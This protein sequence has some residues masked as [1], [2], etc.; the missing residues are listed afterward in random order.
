MSK[1]N[2]L[3]KVTLGAALAGAAG[4]VAGILIAPRTGKQSRK[5]LSNAGKQELIDNQERLKLLYSELGMLVNNAKAEGKVMEGKH[6][7]KFKSVIDNAKESR[8]KLE[9]LV[10][11]VKKGRAEDK[12]LDKAIKDA[13]KAVKHVKR[14]LIHK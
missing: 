12:N 3:K 6:L 7:E 2:L 14:F 9:Q 13:E 11:A 10:D 4:Y 1:K 8:D 5:K